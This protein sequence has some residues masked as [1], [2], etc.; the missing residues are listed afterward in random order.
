MTE[1]CYH[2]TRYEISTTRNSIIHNPC[3]Y[4]Y[5]ILNTF[6][7][8]SGLRLQQPAL[9]PKRASGPL[10]NGAFI[11]RFSPLDPFPFSL[12][13]LHKPLLSSSKAASFV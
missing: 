2:H 9:D 11:S 4:V 1:V 6:R 7:L 8:S 3:I 5:V 12:L 10:E 13:F